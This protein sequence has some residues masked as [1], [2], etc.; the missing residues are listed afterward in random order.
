[1]STDMTFQ[2]FLAYSASAGSGKTFA[3]AV[4]YVSLLFMGVD[5]SNILAATFTNKA[6]SEMRQRVI[7]SL[8]NL[9][10][11]K[12]FLD[13]ISKQTQMSTEELLSK[14][15]DV[16]QKFLSS[17]SHI[18]TL[19]SFFASI[20]RLASLYIGL[21]PDFIIKEESSKKLEEEFLMEVV[22][23]GDIYSLVNL[24]LDIED[25]RFSKIFDIM[26][27]FY[28]LDPLLPSIDFRYK[29]IYKLEDEIQTLR[30]S[31][32]KATID[33]KASK[34][35]IA[36]FAPCS[37]KE[38]FEKSVFDKDSLYEHRYYAKYLSKAPYID[39]IYQE[40]KVLLA[41]WIKAKQAR[42]LSLLFEH[43]EHYKNTIISNAKSSGI[44]SFD[45][46]TYFT[47]RLLYESISKDFLYFKID[48]SFLHILLDEFQDTSSLQY[49][50]LKP[51]IDEIFAG[52]GQNEFRSFFYVGDTKQSLYR[53]RGGVEEL[54][55]KVAHNYD[56]EIKPMDTNYRSAKYI[57]EQVN[58]WFVGKIEGYIPQKSKKD[59]IDG[60]VEVVEDEN[61]I[62]S[63]I[64]TA[65]RLIELGVDINHIAFLVSTNKDGQ[66]L[67]EECFKEGIDTL[68]KTTSSL[69]NIPKIASL[70]AMIE[71]LVYGYEIDKVAFDS[72]I[73]I[74]ISSMDFEW[75]DISLEPLVVIDKLIREFGYYGDDINLLTLLEYAS[76][77]DSISKFVEEF[78]DSMIPVASNTQ[79][80]AK[81]MTIHG[82]KGLEFDFVILLDKLT[83]ANGDRTPILFDYDTSLYIKDIVYR[84][85]G[86]ERF[87]KE[88]ANL[89]QKNKQLSTKDV[90]NVLYVATT[91][92][93]KGMFVVKKPELSLF[94]M[95]DMKP[96]I[97]GDFS[98]L[99]PKKCINKEY[100]EPL[101]V[102][103]L[104]YGSQNVKNTDKQEITSDAIIFGNALHYTLEMLYS[105]DIE[106]ID[107]AMKA[108]YYRYGNLLSKDL[109]EEIKQ[110]VGLLISSQKFQE[111]L[112]GAKVYKE[113]PLSF[114]G[115]IKQIDL[116]LE[117]EDSM[118]VIDYKSSIQD[119]P[120][121]KNQVTYY[122][123]AIESITSKPTKGA[124]VY[125]LKEKIEIILI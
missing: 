94:D 74:D 51:L 89:L 122:K 44:L 79:H 86:K 30:D 90:L 82:S 76:G 120:R 61:I 13:E 68:L 57:V 42:V 87:D 28:K 110:R 125:L 121:H 29:E 64:K 38:L 80:G 53:F 10:T 116:L 8:Q 104:S 60:Y 69:K 23:R 84:Q 73:S 71:Y 99:K 33:V 107:D 85:K 58:R 119:M 4:R 18:V 105:F 117:Y 81:I 45:D 97:L 50:L 112:K 91:R 77:F 102:S 46:L 16:L 17:S 9:G 27:E 98:L 75:F 93:V 36:N 49:L 43:Y 67:Q 62:Q 66:Q 83:K 92:A 2:P 47:Y 123:K 95:I 63:A 7:D 118:L 114:E 56:I 22:S 31:L 78:Q 103:L 24:A 41:S 113:Q 59:A 34:S 6:A 108:M 72:R 101:S 96:F 35:A 14:K 40:L 109:V 111:I 19:D 39:D 48:S 25:K 100:I 124:I 5:A 106:S 115:E 15:T 55:E 11:N 21:E 12:A 3:L 88:Y 26:Q 70:V 32:Y 52:V 37:T 65:K 20:L 54:F 1:M